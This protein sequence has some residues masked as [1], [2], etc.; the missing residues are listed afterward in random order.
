MFILK[1]LQATR[2]IIILESGVH[3]I[4]A[5]IVRLTID[6]FPIPIDRLICNFSRVRH[7]IL[8]GDYKIIAK[9]GN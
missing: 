9:R 4:N 3:Q 8:C 7:C 2:K 5:N 1:N 6:C